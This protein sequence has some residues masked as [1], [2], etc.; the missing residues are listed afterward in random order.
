VKALALLEGKF[1]VMVWGAWI[2]LASLQP[3]ALPLEVS[4]RLCH[5]QTLLNSAC[6]A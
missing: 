6:F 2:C 3:L 4:L 5:T 1:S